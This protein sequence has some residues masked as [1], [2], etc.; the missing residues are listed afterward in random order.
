MHV[1]SSVGRCL[2]IFILPGLL[3]LATPGYADWVLD[4]ERSQLN[5]I[6][7]KAGNIAESHSFGQMSGSVA[8]TGQVR[9][10]IALLSVDTK[11]PIRDERMKEF[12]FES[13][14]FPN[15]TISADVPSELLA[16][17]A[18]ASADNATITGSLAIKDR[19]VDLSAEVTA[20]KL[21]EQTL[22]VSTTQPILVNGAALGLSPGIE[23]LRELAGLPS[24][25][26]AVPVTF[27]LTFEANA[28]S[29]K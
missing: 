4:N 3:L 19:K 13:N 7:I 5:F 27:V 17:L 2:R 16:N 25:S 9:I 15:A 14:I 12:L 28:D 29:G 21:D 24:I 26:Q 8:D 23:K 20:L 10:V 1:E 6:S 11:I 22:V 18:P